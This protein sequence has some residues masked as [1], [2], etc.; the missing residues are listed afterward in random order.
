M[1]INNSNNINHVNLSNN[2]NSVNNKKSENTIKEIELDNKDKAQIKLNGKKDAPLVNLVDKNEL[3]SV[4]EYSNEIFNIIGVNLNL[5]VSDKDKIINIFKDSEK[6]GKFNELI[7]DLNKNNKLEHV[8][9]SLGTLVNQGEAG[10]VTSSVLAIFTLGMSTISEAKMN[11]AYDLINMMEKNNI[12]RE[13]I[14][15]LK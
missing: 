3:K 2:I 13:I 6:N 12:S 15:K 8:Y 14:D 7:N 5:E 10:A 9:K 1:T 4:K 11:R